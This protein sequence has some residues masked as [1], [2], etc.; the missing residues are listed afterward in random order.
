MTL[1]QEIYCKINSLCISSRHFNITGI[2]STTGTGSHGH[3]VFNSSSAVISTP[4]FAFLLQISHPLL[5]SASDPAVDHR[6]L[7]LHIRNAVAKKSAD[8]VI[9]FQIQ[10]P[11]DLFCSTAVLRQ[12]RKD[13]FQQLPWSFLYA[14]SEVC[15]VYPA[16]LHMQSQ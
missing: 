14:P 10:L 12:V 3:I 5:P 13:R 6:F 15:G 16:H 2:G 4:T 9:F 8:P 1:F 7:Q 11:C